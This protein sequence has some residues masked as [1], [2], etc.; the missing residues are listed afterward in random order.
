MESSKTTFSNQCYILGELWLNYRDDEEFKD[1]I[2]YNDIGLPL[3]YFLDSNIVQATPVAEKFVE[4][5]FTLLV[6]ALELEED[7]GFESLEDMLGL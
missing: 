4:E 5:T 2:S 6:K 3:A 1:F 7:T